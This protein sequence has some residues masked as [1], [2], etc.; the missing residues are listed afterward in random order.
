MDKI[1][2]SVSQFR[3]L[4]LYLRPPQQK[5]IKS[6]TGV[7]R[8]NIEDRMSSGELVLWRQRKGTRLLKNYCAPI[9]AYPQKVN[10]LTR[11]LLAMAGACEC[12]PRPTDH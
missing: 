10:W 1:P 6:S 2:G 4:T 9:T 11:V 5:F 8:R 12:R 7:S 3:L